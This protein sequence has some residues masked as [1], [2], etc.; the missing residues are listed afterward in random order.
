[1]VVRRKRELPGG[2]AAPDPIPHTPP[3]PL[4][5]PPSPAEIARA[6]ATHFFGGGAGRRPDS[7]DVEQALRALAPDERAALAA[8]LPHA[9]TGSDTGRRLDMLRALLARLED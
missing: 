9:P 1:M 3:K 8:T 6:A 7:S 2:V 4:P 5:E